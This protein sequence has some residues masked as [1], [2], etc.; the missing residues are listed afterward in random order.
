MKRVMTCASLALLGVASLQAQAV[1]PEGRMWSVSAKLRGFYDDN[2]A[3]A[4]NDPLPGY[5]QK[6]SSWGINVAPSLRFDLLRDLTTLHLGYDYDLRWYENRPDNEIDQTH[7]GEISVAHSFSDRFRLEARDTIVYSSEPSLLEPDGQQ[8][9]FIRTEN[10]AWRNYGA[11]AAN[12]GLT[13][14]LGSRV[15]YQNISYDYDEDGPG[16]RSALLDRME[17]LA[18]LDMRWQFQP[19]VVGIVGYQYGYIDYNSKDY[20]ANPIFFP[21]GTKLA[22]GDDRDQESHYG[23]VGVDY[24]LNPRLAAQARVGVDYATYPNLNV[25]DIVA[26]Y[27]DAAL[28][29][30]Y[31]Q[32]SKFVVGVKHDLRPTDIAYPQADSA[33]TAAAEATTV[34]AVIAHKLTEKL[35]ASVRGSWQMSDFQGGAYDGESDNY[36]TVDATLGYEINRYLTAEVGYAFDKLDSDIGNRGYDRNRFFFGV[37]A[38]Y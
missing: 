37:R 15:Q 36:Y 7:R 31:M 1:N 30:E 14:R 9:T 23:F 4:P 3:T 22:I 19:T 25:D 34:Y 18:T 2:Y 16:S 32:G 26:P 6:A 12:A 17:H 5:P 21:P 27:A 13:E 11:I 33:V 8:A 29:Y 24:T 28:S 38:A 20:L 10:N 35:I